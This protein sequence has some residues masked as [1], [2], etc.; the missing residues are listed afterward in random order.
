[1][2]MLSE[3]LTI[4][5]AT[6]RDV[7]QV[8]A[9]LARAY[10]LLLRADYPPATLQAALPLIARA[11]PHLVGCGSYF[12]AARGGVTLAAGGWT[13]AAPQGA[14]GP[15]GLGHV[16][17]VVTDPRHVRQG[18]G[19]ALMR[20]VMGHAAAAGVHSLHCQSTLTAAPFY[21][22]LGFREVCRIDL[23]LRPGILFPAVH[24]V[25]EQ[26][27]PKSMRPEGCTGALA[28]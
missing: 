22:A 12:I 23:R 9:L 6:L 8:D 4:R 27:G 26:L 13:R 5:L 10:P 14:E 24:M 17:H 1:M 7:P 3:S 15:E 18:I 2:Q 21:A 11:Q 20:A 16:R 19:R 28:P 25:C